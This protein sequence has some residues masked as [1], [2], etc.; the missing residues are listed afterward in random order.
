MLAED[1]SGAA[2]DHVPPSRIFDFDI[3]ND[4]R[5][6]PDPIDGYAELLRQ[7]PDIFYTRKNGGHWVLTRHDHILQALKAPQDFSNRN[8]DIPK[9]ETPSVLLPLTLD[10]PQHTPYRQALS[11]FF[12]AKAMH[13]LEPH[14]RDWARRL[15]DAVIDEGA[16][17]FMGAIGSVLPVSVFMQLMG[18]PLERLAEFRG[19]TDEAFHATSSDERAAIYGRIVGFM[20]EVIEARRAERQDDL[21]SRLIDAEIEGRKLTLEELQGLSLLLFVAGMDTVANAMTFGVQHLAGDAPLQARL[22]AEPAAIP[23]FVEEVLRR[24]AFTNT[25]RMAARDQDFNDVTMR[26][27]DMVFL[28]LTSA[29]L[30][31]QYA[32]DPLRFDARRGL[33][34]HL[35]FGG[36]PHKCVGRHLGRIELRILFEELLQSVQG[37]RMAP[38]AV[39]HIRAGHAMAPDRLDILFERR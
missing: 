10:P 9:T 35:T 31:P 24:Y 25:V 14:I 22:A 19:W 5:F 37:I 13:A 8:L 38:G 17:D 30:D 12:S 2:P 23:G 39:T 21:V 16:C 4:A 34:D 29:G 33:S 36:G 28:S 6:E 3:F 15:I 7:A 1:P 20:T 27:G 26:Q 11:Q 18:L 32:D